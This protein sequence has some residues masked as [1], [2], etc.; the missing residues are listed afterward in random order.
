MRV[1]QGENLALGDQG[2]QLWK[3]QDAIADA[4]F[5]AHTQTAGVCFIIFGKKH[6]FHLSLF[7][8]NYI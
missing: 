5:A 3:T 7:F 8:I 6:S 1:D 2:Q 4:I